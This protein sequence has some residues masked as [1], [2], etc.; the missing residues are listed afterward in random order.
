MKGAK[1]VLGK[2]FGNQQ[3]LALRTQTAWANALTGESHL[4]FLFLLPALVKG[5]ALKLTVE[6]KEAK[7]TKRCS[8]K[9]NSSS[10]KPSPPETKGRKSKRSGPPEVPI[11]A[12]Q[13]EAGQMNKTSLFKKN[14]LQTCA[15]C[16][17]MCCDIL[18]DFRSP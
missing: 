6:K 4:V 8:T 16:S 15:K 17:L 2:L 1:A 9:S 10:T 14:L 13:K 3:K 12:V 18:N 5:S 7:P 11:S